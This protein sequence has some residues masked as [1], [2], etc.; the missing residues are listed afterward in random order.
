MK[1]IRP[2]DNLRRV[3][4][5]GPLFN[6]AERREMLHIAQVLQQAGFETFVPHADGMEFAQVL[7]YLLGQGHDRVFAGQCVH[8][9]VFALDTYHVL[10][11]CG[12]LVFNMNGRTPDEGGVAEM[13]MA[14]MTGKPIVIYKEDVRS[15]IAGR[16][17]PLLVGQTGFV[18]VGQIELLPAML[19]RKISE[20]ELDDSWQVPCP[21]HL[22][23]VLTAGETF[24][25]RLQ[26]LGE[27]RPAPVLGE[28]MLELFG[29]TASL[30]R[31]GSL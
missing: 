31:S 5:A 13:S 18:S 19:A 1:T 3:Y 17:N 11:G 22:A 26:S 28:W 25:N 6:A 15:A 23:S 24:W 30:A 7:P 4:C 27:E 2:L 12:S 29:Q 20:L 8:E 21:P 16:D 10:V 9:A 14:W